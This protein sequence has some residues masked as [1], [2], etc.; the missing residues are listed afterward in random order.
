L[1]V[2]KL[3]DKILKVVEI[4]IQGLVGNAEQLFND[5]GARIELKLPKPT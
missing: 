4:F 2:L 5:G 3:F 1:K